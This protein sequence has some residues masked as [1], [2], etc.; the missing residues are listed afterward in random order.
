MVVKAR[1]NGDAFDLETLANLFRLGDPSVGKDEVGYYVASAAFDAVLPDAV[2]LAEM[3]ESVLRRMNGIARALND[4]FHPVRLA[5]RFTDH[6][7]S[8]HVVVRPESIM[9]RTKVSEVVL[10]VDGETQLPP[11][12][13]LPGYMKAADAQP[14]VAEVLALMGKDVAALDWFD[15][16]KVYEIVRSNVGSESDLVAKNWVPARDLK[17]FTASANL[18]TVSGD[19]ARHAR[20]AAGIPK[21]TMDVR[22]ARALINFLV[23]AW[24]QSL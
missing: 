22:Q 9:V 12:S 7:G 6:D 16:Y 14:D 11:P 20:T 4:N 1:L 15:L 2:R 10:N 8:H 23:V 5:D 19:A 21:H 3:S 18:P 17:A 24:L 13:P